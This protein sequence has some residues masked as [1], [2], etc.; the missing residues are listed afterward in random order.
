MP[1]KSSF[2]FER[3]R[4]ARY[5]AQA[6]RA[7]RLEKFNVPAEIVSSAPNCA[8]RFPPTG[9]A[10]VAELL[11]VNAAQVPDVELQLLL[12]KRGAEVVVVDELEIHPV[13]PAPRE[14]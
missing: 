12:D 3:P 2:V 4:P 6:T 8:G 13:S 5:L 14:F 1:T 9:D 11:A 7:A 10:Q